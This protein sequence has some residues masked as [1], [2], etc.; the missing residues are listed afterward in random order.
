M[1]LCLVIW[2]VARCRE[3]T[4]LTS[5]FCPLVCTTAQPTTYQAPAPVTTMSMPITTQPAPVTYSAPVTYTAPAPV[6]Y[7]MPVQ[8]QPSVSYT[9]QET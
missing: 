4:H 6:T 2:H 8:T 5:L 9:T 3:R 7:T 1:R